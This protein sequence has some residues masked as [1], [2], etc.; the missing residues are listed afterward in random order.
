MMSCSRSISSPV[1]CSL[2]AVCASNITTSTHLQRQRLTFV[3][4]IIQWT[5]LRPLAEFPWDQVPLFLAETAPTGAATGSEPEIGRAESAALIEPALR[6]T[7]LEHRRHAARYWV[8]ARFGS[9]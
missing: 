7:L 5:E 4:A 9:L 1:C 3:N 2:Y 8:V 6:T